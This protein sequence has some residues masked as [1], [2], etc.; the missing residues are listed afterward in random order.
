MRLLSIFALLFLISFVL[1]DG[2]K[3]QLMPEE[4]PLEQEQ[5]PDETPLP[6]SEEDFSGLIFKQPYPVRHFDFEQE[7]SFSV[8]DQEIK[9]L[10]VD[11]KKD[12]S[13][14]MTNHFC[15]VGYEFPRNPQDRKKERFKKEVVV[16][17]RERRALFRWTGGNP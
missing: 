5:E 6:V 4:K 8:I 13:F 10:I 7:S 1:H 12:D 9:N 15:A 14:M 11:W 17:W 2:G 3:D 16:Y